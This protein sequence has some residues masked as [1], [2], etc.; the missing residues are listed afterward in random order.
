MNYNVKKL[1]NYS[2]DQAHKLARPSHTIYESRNET[3]VSIN[4]YFDLLYERNKLSSFRYRLS[5][6]I[7]S[8][9]IANTFIISIKFFE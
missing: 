2:P 8:S 5:G 1:E 7:L 4:M 6:S 3:K 9:I